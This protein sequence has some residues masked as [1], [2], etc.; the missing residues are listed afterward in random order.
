MFVT[1]AI[2]CVASYLAVDHYFS[3]ATALASALM[4][5]SVFELFAVA[6]W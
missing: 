4:L 6:I 1:L 5:Y 3:H 2:L